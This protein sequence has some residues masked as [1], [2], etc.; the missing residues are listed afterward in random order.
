MN[1]YTNSKQRKKTKRKMT[2]KILKLKTVFFFSVQAPQ[3]YN[4]VQYNTIAN[5]YSALGGMPSSYQLHFT[6]MLQHFNY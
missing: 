4:T 1:T 3:Q 5:L 2:T 6:M